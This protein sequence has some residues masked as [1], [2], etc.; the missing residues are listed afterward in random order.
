MS[1]QELERQA[2]RR[3]AVIRHAQEMTGNVPRRAAISASPVRPTLASVGAYEA[4]GVVGLRD[5]SI[6]LALSSIPKRRCRSK[7][8]DRVRWRS[9]PSV[10]SGDPG[11]GPFSP[12]MLTG[13][14]CRNCSRKG[15]LDSLCDRRMAARSRSKAAMTGWPPTS[16]TSTPAASASSLLPTRRLR[17]TATNGL[18][19]G[20]DLPARA[21]GSPIRAATVS[22]RSAPL[23]AVD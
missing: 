23:T 22:T 6:V 21:S 20:N 9:G 10:R 13:P 7:R 2:K 17:C 3:L 19:T 16:S 11:F 4:K 14:M 15:L 5:R 12:L 18:R 8:P 1:E